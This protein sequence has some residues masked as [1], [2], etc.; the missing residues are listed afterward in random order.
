MKL[1][2]TILKK[3]DRIEAKFE[4]IAQHVEMTEER[5]IKFEEELQEL[6][7]TLIEQLRKSNSSTGL[8]H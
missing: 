1:L 7:T 2:N 5:Q 4:E 6:K 8:F 3:L